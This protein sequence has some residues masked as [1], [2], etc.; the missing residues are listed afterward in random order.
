MSLAGNEAHVSFRSD[1]AQTLAKVRKELG[2]VASVQLFSSPDKTGV[3]EAR[4]VVSG[5]LGLGASKQA[6]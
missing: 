6:G 4:A 2:G 1:Q 3:D 5:W